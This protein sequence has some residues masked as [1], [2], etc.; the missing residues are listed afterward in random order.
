[1]SHDQ[2]TAILRG[3]ME[4]ES[5]LQTLLLKDMTMD[6]LKGVDRQLL[7]QATQKI[8]KFIQKSSFK[9]SR[10]KTQLYQYLAIWKHVYKYTSLLR[11]KCVHFNNRTGNVVFLQLFDLFSTSLVFSISQQ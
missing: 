8:G 5:R 2:I 7:K 6:Y 11:I 9:Y 3:V 10:S 1:M 4:G